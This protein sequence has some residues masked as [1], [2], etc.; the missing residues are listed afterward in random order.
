MTDET[1]ATAWP[2][3]E[4]LPYEMTPIARLMPLPGNARKHSKKQIEAI[5]KSFEAFG[6][7]TPVL[8]NAD[9]RIIAGHGRVEAAKAQGKTTV[10]T[11]RVTHLDDAEQR[12]LALA[13]NR[14]AEMSTWDE[15][16]RAGEFRALRLESPDLDLTIS[17]FETAKIEFEIAGLEQTNW[18]DLDHVPDAPTTEPITRLGDAFD[19]QAGHAGLR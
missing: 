2:E 16:K 18:S 5:L 10:A 13:D 11:L 6:F 19:F 14:I 9:N 12:L 15:E 4:L 1:L 17:G 8:I 7:V 3:N